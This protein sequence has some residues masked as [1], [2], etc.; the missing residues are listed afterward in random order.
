MDPIEIIAQIIGI[1]G[2]TVNLLA[3]Q[4]KKQFNLILFQFFGSGLFF[5]N[6]LLLGIANGVIYIGAIMNLLGMF[7]STVF[8]NKKFFH[9]DK[10]FWIAIFSVFYIIAYVLVFTVFG[11]E[12]T[13]KNLIIEFIPVFAMI[14]GTLVVY[15]K[16][17]G[18]ARKLSLISSPSWL[19]Y[20]IAAGSLGGTIGEMLNICSIFIGMLRHDRKAKGEVSDE[21]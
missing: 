15:M 16:N 2:M 19:V 14:A 1:F 5:L 10:P 20:D 18:A 13:P 4:Q 7:R 3:Y 9:S 8:A 6:F 11:T 12:A 21:K 17:A